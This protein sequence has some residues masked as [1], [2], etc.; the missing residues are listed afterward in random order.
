MTGIYLVRLLLGHAPAIFNIRKEVLYT[1]EA[2][3]GTLQSLVK[4]RLYLVEEEVLSAT[5]PSE[6][7]RTERRFCRA[8]PALSMYRR[9]IIYTVRFGGD[10]ST[11]GI[12]PQSILLNSNVSRRNLH[13]GGKAGRGFLPA[14]C[15]HF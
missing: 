2:L 12:P 14:L 11:S 3:V 9:R 10:T 7:D 1:L 5:F 15:R 13:L 8:A 4:P 6:M